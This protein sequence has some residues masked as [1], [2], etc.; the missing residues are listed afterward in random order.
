MKLSKIASAAIALMALSVA[1]TAQQTSTGPAQGGTPAVLQ[2]SKIAVINTEVFQS[3]IGEFKT[4]IDGLNRQFEARMK[5]L[6]SQADKI[7]ALE[8]TIKTQNQV[9]GAAKIAEMTEQ[10]DMM[11]RDYQRKGE[12][13][14]A[15]VG[16][17]R[18]KAFE[19]ITNKLGKF[20]EDYTK[21][22]G[23]TLL[24]DIANA[25]QAGTVLWHDPRMDITKDFI[26]EYNRAHP[27]AAAPATPAPTDKKP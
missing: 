19:P 10:V 14:Q 1:A 27:T 15:D 11:K 16:R 2:K 20:A 8:T 26:A 3:Q 17:A 7:T 9:L 5:D 13:L 4:A 23:I 24:V 6:Q 22:R 18:D 12:D 25:T 21:K